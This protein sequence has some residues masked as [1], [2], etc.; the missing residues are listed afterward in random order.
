MLQFNKADGRTV[1]TYIV[2]CEIES[3]YLLLLSCLVIARE[4]K[5]CFVRFEC[6][7]CL[8]VKTKD[9][10][11]YASNWEELKV[12]YCFLTGNYAIHRNQ[13]KVQWKTTSR[14]KFE[15]KKKNFPFTS[16]TIISCYF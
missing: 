7:V 3:T 5:V 1:Y 15:Q 10:C 6:R 4:M 8:K 14:D 2:C 11:Y 12:D 9:R 16:F 13:L